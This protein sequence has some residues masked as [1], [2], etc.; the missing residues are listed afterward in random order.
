MAIN[1]VSSFTIKDNI[2]KSEIYWCLNTIMNHYSAN[3]SDKSISVIKLMFP[4]CDE[5]QKIQLGRTKIGYYTTFG[6]A[7]YFK[8]EI[9]EEANCR[10]RVA[11]GFDESFNKVSK[12]GQMDVNLRYWDNKKFEV[13]TRYF[14]SSFLGHAAADDILSAFLKSVDGLNLRKLLQVSMDGPNVNFSFLKLLKSYLEDDTSENPILFDLGSCGIHTLHNAFK[15]G[16]KSVEWNIAQFLSSIYNLFC[17]VP[18]RPA[19]F[20]TYTGSD[21]FPLKLCWIRWVENYN[22]AERAIKILPYLEK[23]VQH[24]KKIKKEPSCNS[25]KIICEHLEDKLLKAKLNYFAFLAI[26][27]QPF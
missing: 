3:S 22:V 16:F 21:L 27:V 14:I 25:Y 5:A 2:T 17:N 11:A 9:L 15:V 26:T 1:T 23:Y 10:K 20:I 7:P 12:K 8:K 13:T 6:L 24:C 18:A 19:D 4:N